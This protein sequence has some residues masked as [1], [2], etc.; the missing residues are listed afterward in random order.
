MI[1]MSVSQIYF[2]QEEITSSTVKDYT[3][4]IE[5]ATDVL[6]ISVAGNY[7]I[8][9]N[10]TLFTKELTL[11]SN[12][13]GRIKTNV[14]VKAQSNSAQEA[15]ITHS[16][17]QT[18]AVLNIKAG[19]APVSTEEKKAVTHTLKIPRTPPGQKTV[20]AIPIQAPDVKKWAF[21]APTAVFGVSDDTQVFFDNQAVSSSQT[22]VRFSPN[23]FGTYTAVLLGYDAQNTP[24]VKVN[25]TASSSKPLPI[26]WIGIGVAA[27]IVLGVL[28]YYYWQMEDR[29]SDGSEIG[30]LRPTSRDTIVV[31]F[32]DQ[33]NIKDQKGV[34]TDLLK[35]IPHSIV[36][37]YTYEKEPIEHLYDLVRQKKVHLVVALKS[38]ADTTSFI[39]SAPYT[40]EEGQIGLMRTSYNQQW[41]QKINQVINSNITT[42]QP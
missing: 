12:K 1:V 3:L 10:G 37:V 11:K 16:I 7:E 39:W 42:Q 31:G 5:Q 14:R 27:T 38:Q 8:S 34:E 21:Q 19:V 35:S 2:T 26:K 13:F 33:L 20:K 18:T 30:D 41:I 9:E 25:V 4:Q 17:G 28:G 23:D 6:F 32:S 24:L 29:T 22:F 15:K 36:D 40:V